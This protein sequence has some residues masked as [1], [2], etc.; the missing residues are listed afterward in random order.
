MS[1]VKKTAGQGA[2]LLTDVGPVIA[3]ILVYNIGRNFA[4]DQAIYWATGVFMAGV[5]MALGYAGVVQ[6]RF[7]PMLVVSAVIVMSFGGM[8]IYLQDPIFV[9]IKPTIINLLYSFAILGSFAFGFNVWKALFGSVFTLPERIWWILAVRWALFF[10]ILALINEFLWRHIND[11]VV[12]ESARWFPQL[13]W[14]ES[15]WANGKLGIM[16][17]TFV[18]ALANIPIALRHQTDDDDANADEAAPDNA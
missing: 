15:L 4:G 5:A 14:S 2:Q 16:A 12:V 6:K 7:P 11:S 9:Y 13:A 18:F 10:Q 1:Q 3:F 17:L 8:T